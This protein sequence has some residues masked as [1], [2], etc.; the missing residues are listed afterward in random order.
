MLRKALQP[1]QSLDPI[2][3]PWFGV[4]SFGVRV[5]WTH[6]VEVAIHQ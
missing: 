6:V 3:K 4:G 2:L 5:N 1:N